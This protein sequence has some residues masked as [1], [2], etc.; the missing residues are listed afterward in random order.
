VQKTRWL[1]LKTRKPERRTGGAPGF[2]EEVQSAHAKLSDASDAPGYLRTP[3]DLLAKKKLLQWCRWVER[4][5]TRVGPAL[6]WKMADCAGMIRAPF[7]AS[8]RTGRP[9]RPTLFMEGL[10][11][12]L[13]RDQTQGPRLSQPREPDRHA[14]TS[15]PAISTS[16]SGPTA[17]PLP[18][19]LPP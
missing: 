4:T 19:P 8:W 12:R 2:A 10:F 15:P 6:F 11:Q 13:L 9:A 16:P 18:K 14:L 5:A 7:P 3:G 17:P 1:W